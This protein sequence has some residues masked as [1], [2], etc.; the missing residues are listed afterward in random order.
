MTNLPLTKLRRMMAM[1]QQGSL[2]FDLH[3]SGA[4]RKLKSEMRQELPANDHDALL[5]QFISESRFRE[6]SIG[7]VF[8][9]S[10]DCQAMS[11]NHERRQGKLA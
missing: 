2:R 11:H 8:P 3:L 4:I 10:Q 7:M 6:F 5:R 1:I 9:G